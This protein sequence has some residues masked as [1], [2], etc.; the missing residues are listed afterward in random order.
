MICLPLRQSTL[1]IG[2]S[3]FWCRTW[4]LY[5]LFYLLCVWSPNLSSLLLFSDI[6]N[7]CISFLIFISISYWWVLTPLIFR[8]MFNIVACI[9]DNIVLLNYFIKPLISLS[10][11]SSALVSHMTK[12]TTCMTSYIFKT[13]EWC[14]DFIIP[15]LALTLFMTI[16]NANKAC[17]IKFVSIRLSSGDYGSNC[18]RDSAFDWMIY[19]AV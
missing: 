17:T 9:I 1:V 11:F 3:C 15:I 5:Q 4:W 10:S 2:C 16:F 12:S 6:F 19:L 14:I 18:W 13:C 8:N 7:L